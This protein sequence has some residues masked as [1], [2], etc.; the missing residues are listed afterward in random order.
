MINRYTIILECAGGTYVEQVDARDEAEAVSKW[1]RALLSYGPIEDFTD[2]FVSEFN[3]NYAE[4]GLS[5]LNNRS[6]VWY[7]QFLFRRKI[8]WGHIVRSFVACNHT[9]LTSVDG[10]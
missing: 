5:S 6:E 1:C 8:A 3:K 10:P 7:F 9:E 4:R 2:E